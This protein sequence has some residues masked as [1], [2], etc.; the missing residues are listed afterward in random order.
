MSD[1]RMDEMETAAAATM[2]AKLTHFLTGEEEEEFNFGV[3]VD[4]GIV[5]VGGH[6]S[7][8]WEPGPLRVVPGPGFSLYNLAP[9]PDF[10]SRVTTKSLHKSL[11]V[12]L[13]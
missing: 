3:C 7:K 11:Q 5:D 10:H 6:F 4:I 1:E 13:F 12:C 9:V 2:N 8:S